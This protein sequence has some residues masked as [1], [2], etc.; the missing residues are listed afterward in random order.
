MRQLQTYELMKSEHTHPQREG[1]FVSDETALPQFDVAVSGITA[2]PQESVLD[3]NGNTLERYKITMTDGRQLNANV[4]TTPHPKN[5]R[6]ILQTGAWLTNSRGHNQNSQR[7]LAEAGYD[8]LFIGHI[9]EERASISEEIGRLVLKPHQVLQEIRGISLAR[10]AHTITEAA[11]IFAE[12]YGKN[13]QTFDLYGESR[14]AMTGLGVMAYSPLAGIAINKAMLVAP[15]FETA[16]SDRVQTET[17]M[18]LSLE[19][20]NALKGLGQVSVKRLLHYPSTINLSPKSLAY[21]LAHVKTLLNGDAGRFVKHIP[22]GQ[23]AMI[24]AFDNDLAGQR[25]Y[26]RRAFVDH[27]NVIIQ[28]APGGHISGIIDR[29]T[30]NLTIDYLNGQARRLRAYRQ[31]A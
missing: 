11:P 17:S 14:G 2:K 8:S 1:V 13:T 18:Q 29:R 30:I 31:A 7:K 25:K 10:Q 19:V 21:E 5:D 12:M 20:F 23:N 16:L 26:W 28:A 22:H 24:L 27:S 4:Y 3:D 15:C 6:F 9:G